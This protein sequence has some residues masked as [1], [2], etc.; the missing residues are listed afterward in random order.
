MAELLAGEAGEALTTATDDATTEAAANREITNGN[1]TEQGKFYHTIFRQDLDETSGHSAYEILPRL[2][3]R[4]ADNAPD[5]DKESVASSEG[6][7]TV[8]S[9]A[10]EDAGSDIVEGNYYEHDLPMEET[11]YIT[12][13]RNNDNYPST[14]ANGDMLYNV[15]G[16]T[17]DDLNG[18][19]AIS[20]RQYQ[21]IHSALSE[22]VDDC[23]ECEGTP[24]V[25][26]TA[27]TVANLQRARDL[28]N[29]N[30]EL[31]FQRVDTS[32]EYE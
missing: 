14:N 2:T 1:A 29:D 30:D 28:L 5:G 9:D 16:L 22:F 7:G 32:I 26:L 6:G 21:N 31:L 11:A 12:V 25:A 18:T 10:D 4:E 3:L 8:F 19:S 15:G 23:E 24:G 20:F 13:E 27:T 17:D